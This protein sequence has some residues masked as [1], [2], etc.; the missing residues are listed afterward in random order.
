MVLVSFITTDI[1]VGQGVS[2]DLANLAVVIP[3]ETNLSI[4]ENVIYDSSH[5]G[6]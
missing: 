3:S 1:D 4:K 6:P 2:T 5:T